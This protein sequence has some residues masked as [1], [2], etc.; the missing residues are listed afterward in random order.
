MD[1]QDFDGIWLISQLLCILYEGMVGF[2]SQCQWD[3]SQVTTCDFSNI[4]R[5][6]DHISQSLNLETSQNGDWSRN[7]RSQRV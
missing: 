6:T 3:Q 4:L 5:L 1:A 2:I 7:H